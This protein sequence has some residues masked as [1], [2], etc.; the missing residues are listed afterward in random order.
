MPAPRQRSFLELFFTV[1]RFAWAVVGLTLSVAIGCRAGAAGI[2]LTTVS[3]NVHDPPGALLT[4]ILVYGAALVNGMGKA[5]MTAGL[6]TFLVFALAFIL[7]TMVRR[8]PYYGLTAVPLIA[9]VYLGALFLAAGAGGRMSA[10]ASDNIFG[11]QSSTLRIG[12]TLL[13]SEAAV[14]LILWTCA[15]GLLSLGAGAGLEYLASAGLIK[16][17]QAGDESGPPRVGVVYYSGRGF[18]PMCGA[19]YRV[20]PAVCHNCAADLA[21]GRDTNACP[22]CGFGMCTPEDRYCRKCA[23]N[24]ELHRQWEKGL[25]AAADRVAEAQAHAEA[26]IEAAKAPE[27]EAGGPETKRREPRP[28]DGLPR[29]VVYCPKCGAEH[30]VAMHGKCE[31][32]RQIGLPL[33]ETDSAEC[34]VCATPVAR[35]D[36]YCWFCGG[37]LR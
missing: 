9:V 25:T 30:P 35:S 28:P 33:T 4:R 12:G 34:P 5:G 26:E 11:I 20:L 29:K 15:A 16:Y 19:P 6:V 37:E 18:C 36:A 22:Y 31:C 21:V 17:G 10:L 1:D 27:A 8:E 32:G 13:V 7:M 3:S 23:A 2:V 24:L 14:A